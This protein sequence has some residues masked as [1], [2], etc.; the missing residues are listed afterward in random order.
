MEKS[1]PVLVH[2]LRLQCFEVGNWRSWQCQLQM[3]GLLAAMHGLFRHVFLKAFSAGPSARA[4]VAREEVLH[5]NEGE[6]IEERNEALAAELA[7]MLRVASEWWRQE[8]SF[9]QLFVL[10][11]ALQ[12][13]VES[14]ASL[15]ACASCQWDRDQ[16]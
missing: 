11:V 16:A 3:P 5:P 10:R 14:M 7:K 6:G 15:L 4:S 1:L 12:A 2:S 9:T 8:S 13:E